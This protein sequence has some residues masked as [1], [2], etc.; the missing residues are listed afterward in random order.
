[1]SENQNAPR[2][3]RGASTKSK[4]QTASQDTA[5]DEILIPLC[6]Q[7]QRPNPCGDEAY[8]LSRSQP[9]CGGHFSTPADST[10][11]LLYRMDSAI[12]ARGGDR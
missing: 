5:Q 10:A 11:A 6:Y 2:D 4:N 3:Q 1:M 8:C 7:G 9:M 12:D